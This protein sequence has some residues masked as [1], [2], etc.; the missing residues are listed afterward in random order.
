MKLD[1]LYLL[2]LLVSKECIIFKVPIADDIRSDL[3][4]KIGFAGT[5]RSSENQIFDLISIEE[6]SF[7]YFLA[8]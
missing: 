8:L 4:G 7:R 6:N 3:L 5:G 2:F 1:K